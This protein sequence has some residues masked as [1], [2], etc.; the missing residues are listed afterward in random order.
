MEDNR[1]EGVPCT[2]DNRAEEPV[3]NRTVKFEQHPSWRGLGN[4]YNILEGREMHASNPSTPISLDTSMDFE[5]EP[6]SEDDECYGQLEA[7][8]VFFGNSPRSDVFTALVGSSSTTNVTTGARQENLIFD[9]S[10]DMSLEAGGPD[11]L[12]PAALTSEKFDRSFS[13]LS[14]NIVGSTFL[15]GPSYPPITTTHSHPHPRPPPLPPTTRIF[16]TSTGAV[17][18]ASSWTTTTTTAVEERPFSD[19]KPTTCRTTLTLENVQSETL[20]SVTQIIIQS[21]TKVTVETHW[22]GSLVMKT[23]LGKWDR[24]NQRDGD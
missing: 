14:G 8:D 22:W 5:D 21:G 1:P 6:D 23:S 3:G 20:N 10:L 15:C 4:R 2:L 13:A 18:P 19:W 24:R 7:G 12:S 16:A 11:C 9:P 17:L